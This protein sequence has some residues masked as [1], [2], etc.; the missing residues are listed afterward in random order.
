MVEDSVPTVRPSGESFAGR[1]LRS[2]RDAQTKASR[3]RELRG[4]SGDLKV[5]R[6]AAG[7]GTPN[8]LLFMDFSV[9]IQVYWQLQHF[10]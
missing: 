5:P 8:I 9:D 7:P 2:C 4:H 1:D 6:E 3:F 10:P